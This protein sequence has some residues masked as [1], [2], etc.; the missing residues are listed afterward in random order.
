MLA[1]FRLPRF[2]LAAGLLAWAL[3]ALTG[4]GGTV[5]SGLG[6]S[7]ATLPTEDLQGP[8]TYE[9]QLATGANAT[10]ITQ[11]GVLV[12]FERGDSV[13]LYN[14]ASVQAMAQQFH[15]AM[16]FARE[17]NAAST[18]DLQPDAT[19]GPGRA[20][21]TALSQLGATTGH[22]ELTNAPVIPY[23]FSAAGVLSATLTN[24]YPTRILGAIPYAAGSAHYDLDDLVVSPGASHIPMLVLANAQDTASGTQRSFSFF[25][26]GW[27]QGAPWAFAVQNMTDHCC[28][29]TTRDV[30]LAWITALLQAQT[31]TGSSGQTVLTAPASPAPPTVRFLCNPNGVVDAQADTNCQFASASLLPSITGGPTAGWLPN[32]TAATAWLTWVTNTGTN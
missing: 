25:Q 31:T 24:A 15:L 7:V 9:L 12:I 26:R 16:L 14:D 10:A 28:T 32:A 17:C 1:P 8:C 22:P 30:T 18:G 2:F 19:K 23:G 11:A 3:T 20:L 29:L 13:D 4:C 21:F 5:I 6:T 27:A